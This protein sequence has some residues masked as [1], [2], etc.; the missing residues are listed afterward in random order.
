MDRRYP[1]SVNLNADTDFPYLVLDA[2]ARHSDPKPPGF[3]VMHHHEDIQLIL[4]LEGTV[5]FRTLKKVRFL[6]AGEGVFI[7]RGTVHQVLPKADGHYNSFLFPEKLVGGYAGSANE[8]LARRLTRA[9]GTPSVPLS[10]A[11]P[12]QAEILNALQR[13]SEARKMPSPLYPMI[14]TRELIGIFVLLLENIRP[15]TKPALGGRETRLQRVLLM[16]ERRYA[17]KITLDDMCEAANVSRSA[18]LRDFKDILSTTPQRYLEDLRLKKAAS[19]L[20]DTAMPVGEI[21]AAVGYDAA[22][23]FGKRFRKAVGMTPREY[24][25]AQ[26][27]VDSNSKSQRLR[28]MPPA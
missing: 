21:A 15:E 20:K 11:V 9:E 25:Q 1:E 26:R 24:R 28:S 10:P 3:R 4:V 16:I 2:D 23:H 7:N 8:A 14:V 13:L 27:P 5:E 12:W 18:L 17:E 6:R 22:S 19:L